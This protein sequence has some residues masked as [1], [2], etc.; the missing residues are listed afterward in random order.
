MHGCGA[1]DRRV[2]RCS[3]WRRVPYVAPRGAVR[4]HF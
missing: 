3:G 2:G 1:T 4:G